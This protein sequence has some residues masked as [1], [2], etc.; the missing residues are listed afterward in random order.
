[1]TQRK[2]KMELSV[3][4]YVVVRTNHGELFTKVT[5]LNSKTLRVRIQ[6]AGK[7]KYIKRHYTD[8]LEVVDF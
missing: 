3:G 6:V 4:D 2:I 5:K 7:F 8:I 1:M